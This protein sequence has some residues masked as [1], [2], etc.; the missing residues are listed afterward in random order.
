MGPRVG[1]SKECGS[2][3]D[4]YAAIA[5]QQSSVKWQSSGLRGTYYEAKTR[6]STALKTL[7]MHDVASICPLSRSD[8]D[9]R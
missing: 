1:A 3:R 9:D 2:G 6:V 4:M 7:L 5:F 8:L